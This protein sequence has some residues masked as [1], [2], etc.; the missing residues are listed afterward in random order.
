MKTFMK[1]KLLES[2]ILE[3]EDYTEAEWKMI[4]RIYGMEKADR[5]EIRGY[6]FRAYG[7]RKDF[8]GT[9]NMWRDA[10]VKL[11]ALAGQCMLGDRDAN[12][13]TYSE[14]QLLFNKYIAGYRTEE[15]YKEIV[16]FVET[17]IVHA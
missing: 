17:S 15:F 1:E 8:F 16:D 7:I 4:E 5:I 12:C 3:P 2:I 9:V 11:T 10:Y 13:E 14:C 6:E